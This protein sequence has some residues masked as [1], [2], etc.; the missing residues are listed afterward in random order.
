MNTTILYPLYAELTLILNRIAT[1]G[2]NNAACSSIKEGDFVTLK[3]VRGVVMDVYEH[4]SA[5]APSQLF[6]QHCQTAL[7]TSKPKTMEEMLYE[8]VKERTSSVPVE[9]LLG[10]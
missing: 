8:L 10:I 2:R 3:Q 9:T 4:S 5:E 6:R 7:K 1:E